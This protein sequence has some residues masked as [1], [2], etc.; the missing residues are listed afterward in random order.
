MTGVNW[1][2]EAQHFGG[3]TSFER[4]AFHPQGVL[5]IIFSQ[6]RANSQPLNNRL[7]RDTQSS[8]RLISPGNTSVH[9]SHRARHIL[10]R[11]ATRSFQH[12]HSKSSP[13]LLSPSQGPAFSGLLSRIRAS[14]AAVDAT[15]SRSFSI[16]SRSSESKGFAQHA[17]NSA[18]VFRSLI[19]SLSICS[20][21]CVAVDSSAAIV[22]GVLFGVDCKA[23]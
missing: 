7:M 21:I 14:C 8:P 11:T 13:T 12:F 15:S 1:S 16:S 2:L 22:S 20:W 4:L 5:A 19:L 17:V 9:L 3:T 10:L 23:W 6:Y 18:R